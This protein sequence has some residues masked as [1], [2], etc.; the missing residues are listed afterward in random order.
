M[1]HG[2]LGEF[3]PDYIHIVEHI[4]FRSALPSSG[5][6]GLMSKGITILIIKITL[7]IKTLDRIHTIGSSHAYDITLVAQI[8]FNSVHHTFIK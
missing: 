6:F 5:L 7:F 4:T 2:N 8:S 3:L 1:I